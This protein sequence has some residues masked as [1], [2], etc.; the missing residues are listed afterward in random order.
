MKD[1]MRTMRLCPSSR[2]RHLL[3][4]LVL[5]LHAGALAATGASEPGQYALEPRH[6]EWLDE[7]DYIITKQELD[8]FL[9]L[10]NVQARDQ[11]IEIFWKVRDPTPG[12]AQNEYRDEHRRRFEHANRIYGRGTARPGWKTDRGRMYIV[13]G[14]P[15]S[16]SRY[17]SSL[18]TVE[19]ETWFYSGLT[20][21]GVPP[22][23]RLLFY[24]PDNIGEHRLFVPGQDRPVDLML[25]N[26]KTEQ[27]ENILDTLHYVDPELAAAA[28]SIRPGDSGSILLSAGD[29]P[30]VLNR[31]ARAPQRT[32][33]TSYVQRIASG[34]AAVELEY[35]F[36]YTPMASIARLFYHPG[37]G[38]TL[39]YALEIQPQNLTLV[40]YQNQIYTTLDVLGA[41]K[42]RQDRQVVTIDEQTELH[43]KPNELERIRYRPVNFHGRVAALPGTFELSLLLKSEASKQYARGDQK[44]EAADP[45][46]TLVWSSTP[47][48]CSKFEPDAPVQPEVE[49]AFQFGSFRL[50]PQVSATFRP[51]DKPLVYVQLY[52]ARLAPE[53]LLAHRLQVELLDAAGNAVKSVVVPLGQAVRDAD[54]RVH[55]VAEL[56]LAG[57]GTADYEL[58]STLL[59][60][61]G[62][63]H[64]TVR[65]APLT[66]ASGAG[67]GSPWLLSRGR[68]APRSAE[69]AVERARGS[70]ALDDSAAAIAELERLPFGAD[71][72]AADLLLQAYLRDGQ[73]RKIVEKLAPAVAGLLYSQARL[74]FQQA[75]WLEALADAHAQ[76]DEWP[77][78]LLFLERLAQEQKHRPDLLLKLERAQRMLGKTAE[79]D[80]AL[81]RACELDPAAEPCQRRPPQERR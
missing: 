58:R 10:D 28:V 67:T 55:A 60:P 11:F 48:P 30:M 3:A 35:S 74:S 33:D 19:S 47:L 66:L 13:L 6:H 5:A 39:D 62:A 56:E 76:L 78:Q 40:Q 65:R 50:Y 70:M 32:V 17:T 43:L 38:M 45:A 34:A 57:L 7:V 12:S 20:L 79:A 31:V 49:K 29:A 36:S 53:R 59:G 52:S 1:P 37:S 73:P 4:V 21:P 71:P 51:I 81:Q 24:R 69:A 80:A 61:D 54:G 27:P 68:P 72:A 41:L 16:I 23:L 46:K 15:Q 25:A 26:Q 75:M 2:A 14:K 8:A 44:L 22:F 63:L 64:E 77:Q 9:A 42:D 18:T